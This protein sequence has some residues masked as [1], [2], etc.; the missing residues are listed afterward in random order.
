[1]TALGFRSS[2]CKCHA[3][4]MKTLLVLLWVENFVSSG[5]EYRGGEL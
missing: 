1:M 3:G 2:F 5:E 4:R